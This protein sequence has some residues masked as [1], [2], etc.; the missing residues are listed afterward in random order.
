MDKISIENYKLVRVILTTLVVLVLSITQA[1]QIINVL[2]LNNFYL[3]M[4]YRRV[5][6]KKEATNYCIRFGHSLWSAIS[7]Q[8][9]W[10]KEECLAL[11]VGLYNNW[12]ADVCAVLYFSG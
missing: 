4:S 3:V 6:K 7:C 5:Q 9:K 10:L 1:K 8:R 12:T 2:L 11:L